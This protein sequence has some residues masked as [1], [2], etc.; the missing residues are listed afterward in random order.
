MNKILSILMLVVMLLTLCVGAVAENT[1]EGQVRN[2]ENSVLYY[3]ADGEITGAKNIEF[4]T[5]KNGFYFVIPKGSEYKYASK[6]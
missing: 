3:D 4:T 6:K 2:P 5:L 1:P